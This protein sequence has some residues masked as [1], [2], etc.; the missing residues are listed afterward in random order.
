MVRNGSSIAM[1]GCLLTGVVAITACGQ[2]EAPTKA[3]PLPLA[4]LATESRAFMIFSGYPEATTR[5]VRD[6]DAWQSAWN[7]I[8]RNLMPVPPLPDVD[9][10]A[11]MIVLAAMGTRPSSGY[12]IV[13]TGASETN[14]V[15]TV[16]A[17]ARSPG[18][19]CVTLTVL[20]SPLDVARIPKRPASVVFHTT[21]I[22][23]LCP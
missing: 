21:S 2:P 16:E 18:P 20:T 4:R 14:A 22:T 10:S 13:L 15:V 23:V 9:F 6:R 1:R 12:D 5:V 7:E 3:T 8:H 17:E 11:E 19:K